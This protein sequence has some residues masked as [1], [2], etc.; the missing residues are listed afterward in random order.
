MFSRFLMMLKYKYKKI[1]GKKFFL[2]LNFLKDK[3]II[4]KIF[5]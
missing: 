3:N 4:I 1:Y 5:I 2:N